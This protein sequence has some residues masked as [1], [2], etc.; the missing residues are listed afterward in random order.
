MTGLAA[1]LAAALIGVLCA[2]GLCGWLTDPCAWPF[3]FTTIPPVGVPA[4]FAL[5]LAAAEDDGC[6]AYEFIE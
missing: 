5:A 4:P 1:V 6:V 2:A 3:P